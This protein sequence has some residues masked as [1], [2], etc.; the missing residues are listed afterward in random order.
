M[1]IKI[2]LSPLES[3]KEK[4]VDE[5]TLGFGDR[6]TDHMLMVDYDEGQGWHDARIVP[7]ADLCLDPAAMFIHYAQS[8][9][10]GLKC[11]RRK[12]GGVQ[13]FR[14][15][16]NFN[17]LNRTAERLCMPQL[18]PEFGLNS[19]LKLLEVEK[20]W[21]PRSQGASLY[22]R[23]TMIATEPHLGVRPANQYLYFVILGPVGP[24]YK[25]GFNPIKIYV[26]K[27]YS[28]AVRGGVGHIKASGNY[29]ASLYAAREAQEKGYTQILW[30][31]AVER[32]YVE[33]VGTSNMFFLFEDELVTPPLGG[34]ILGGVTRQT[35]M[36][37]VGEWGE[38]KVNERLISIDEVMT[39]AENGELKEAFGSGTAVV[40]SPVG[41]I[42]Y[43]GQTVEIGGGKTGP[44]AQRLFDEITSIQYGDIKDTNNWIE[45]V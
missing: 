5:S 44:L 19:L 16:D 33:E 22:V 12:D 25:E 18:D 29:A 4:P 6:T 35:V 21:V 34:S 2:D 38:V 27:D 7:Y 32:K 36:D 43:D 13:I 10:E 24:Y 30:L 37:L 3:R 17:R 8:F 20:E 11:Y 9:F 26:T 45:T 1:D 39:R 14:P 23:P 40:I 41:E 42:H 28:R 31:D 15:K